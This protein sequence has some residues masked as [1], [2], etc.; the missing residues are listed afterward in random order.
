MDRFCAVALE[1]S[2]VP[3]FFGAV[4]LEPW[5]VP[6]SARRRTV[7]VRRV[8]RAAVTDRRLDGI[9][10]FTPKHYGMEPESAANGFELSRRKRKSERAMRNAILT[11][12]GPVFVLAAAV[13]FTVYPTPGD[14]WATIH[15]K[16]EALAPAETGGSIAA[17]SIETTLDRI[18]DIPGAGDL[19]IAADSDCFADF[20]AA[21]Q[22]KISRCAGALYRTLAEL[23]KAARRDVN[24][25][26]PPPASVLT[27]SDAILPQ[28]KLAA[29][30]VCRQKWS[31]E[32]YGKFDF[33]SPACEA[34]DVRLAFEK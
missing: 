26:A 15:P 4:A 17:H 18:G 2:P 11:I 21:D 29:A 16:P 34:A 10:M 31:R 23:D 28:I 7:N 27:A 24:S 30:E 9:V 14:L 5:P 25:A 19:A 22:R 6:A 1:P 3:D 12:F 8:F 13:T 32:P 20:A 33:N